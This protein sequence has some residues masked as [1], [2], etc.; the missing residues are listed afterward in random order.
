M[1]ILKIIGWILLVLLILLL[2]LSF[3]MPKDVKIEKSIEIDAPANMVHNVLNNLKTHEVWNPWKKS[4]P[5]MEYVYGDVT[6]GK[7]ASYQWTSEKMGSGTYTVTESNK[8]E[9]IKSRV[10]FEKGGGDQALSVAADG[11]KS[12]VTWGFETKMSWPSNL[13][14]PFMKMGLGKNF[15]SGL[16]SLRDFVDARKESKEYNGFK[17]NETDLPQKHYVM[18]RQEVKMSNIGQYYGATLGALFGTVQKAG[19]EMDGMPCGLFFDWNETDMTTDMAAA[20]P[21]KEEMTIKDASSH[22]IPAGPALQI[23]YYGDYSG[24][25]DAHDAMDTFLDDYGLLKNFPVVEEYVTDPTTV[26][27]PSK[28]LTRI[29]YY[30]GNN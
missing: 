6:K 7:G 15:K 27:D 17:I 2:I 18:N 23:D 26:T 25:K 14:A 5:T 13:F 9:G 20:I 30:L 21:V 24:T 29:T 1:K 10:D 22:S 3:V 16:R 11:K 19:V 4:D 28:V 12:K 8:E